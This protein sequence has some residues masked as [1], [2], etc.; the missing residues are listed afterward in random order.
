MDLKK[1]IWVFFP[2]R[3]RWI[4]G[5]MVHFG[6]SLYSVFLVN[7]EG[8]ERAGDF[9]SQGR[10]NVNHS[11]SQ[12]R[13]AVGVA[14]GCATPAARHRA[15]TQQSLTEPTLLS[16]TLRHMGGGTVMERGVR[17][18]FLHQEALE[19]R[20][21]WSA[22]EE[23]FSPADGFF[24]GLVSKRAEGYV[25]RRCIFGPTGCWCGILLDL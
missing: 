16:Q 2:G 8:I 1:F 20:L 9:C 18:G 21:V 11:T 12:V 7:G 22:R 10:R 25:P 3:G 24:I 17:A 19:S 23:V 13:T 6:F 15:S 4:A 5:E 14:F